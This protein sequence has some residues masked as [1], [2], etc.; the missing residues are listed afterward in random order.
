MYYEVNDDTEELVL[1]SIF[2]NTL[3]AW[4]HKFHKYYKRAFYCFEC[5]NSFESL[6]KKRQKDKL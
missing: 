2:V 5:E 4:Y 1:Q 6:V 3:Q